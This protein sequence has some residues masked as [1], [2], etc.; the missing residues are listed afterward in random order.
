M[1]LKQDLFLYVRYAS[2]QSTADKHRQDTLF[3]KSSQSA[4]CM[5][6]IDKLIITG[7]VISAS[8]NGE[9][10]EKGAQKF[11]LEGC[12][13]FPKTERG[14]SVRHSGLQRTPHSIYLKN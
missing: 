4:I 13:V 11:S 1:Y 9:R 12:L 6:E 10:T 3:S 14:I 7:I 8:L 2:R 5:V